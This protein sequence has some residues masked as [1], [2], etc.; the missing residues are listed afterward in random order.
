MFELRAS[1]ITGMG[2]LQFKKKLNFLMEVQFMHFIFGLEIEYRWQ[3]G[4]EVLSSSNSAEFKLS[5][6]F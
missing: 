6:H 2:E 5:A 1:M 4:R 3:F